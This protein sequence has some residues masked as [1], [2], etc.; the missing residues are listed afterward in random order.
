ML[1]GNK[2]DLGDKRQ[3]SVEEGE[4]KAKESD[5]MFIETSAKAGFNI[6]SLFRKVAIALPGMGSTEAT[7]QMLDVNLKKVDL[8][9]RSGNKASDSGNCAC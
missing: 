1:V 6:K 7:N 4:E 8:D 5:I 9:Q 3:V 2:T